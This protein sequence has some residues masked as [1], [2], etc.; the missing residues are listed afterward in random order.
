MPSLGVG[1]E[2]LLWGRTGR[3]RVARAS[4]KG[5]G[6]GREG[7]GKGAALSPQQKE[8]MAPREISPSVSAVRASGATGWFSSGQTP[9]LGKIGYC[10]LSWQAQAPLSSGDPMAPPGLAWPHFLLLTPRK[11]PFLGCRMPPGHPG[12]DN[13][14]QA[15]EWGLSAGCAIASPDPS[16]RHPDAPGPSRGSLGHMRLDPAPRCSRF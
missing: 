3:L 14:Q 10:P 4:S 7:G 1:E 8:V 15:P 11:L 16:P 5:P 12:L 6:G 9:Q 2:G 13:V